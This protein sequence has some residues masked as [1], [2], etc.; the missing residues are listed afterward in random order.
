MK[1]I[2]IL[3]FSLLLSLALVPSIRS[4]SYYNNIGISI[5]INQW[6]TEE[7]EELLEGYFDL[8]IPAIQF[9]VHP[10]DRT[11]TEQF[12]TRVPNYES[13]AYLQS[14]TWV[15]YLAYF[16]TADYSV[17]SNP[18]T[19]VFY[20]HGEDLYFAS[21][22]KVVKINGV[23]EITGVSE[24]ITFPALKYYEK[25]DIILNYYFENETFEV[26]QLKSQKLLIVFFIILLG[27]SFS[28][29]HFLVRFLM[30]NGLR[31]D[32]EI[33]KKILFVQLFT[34]I[35]ASLVFVQILTLYPVYQ[36]NYLSYVFFVGILIFETVGLYLIF[37]DKIKFKDAAKNNLLSYIPY[38]FII[39]LL[40]IL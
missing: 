37:T 11:F 1:K 10:I 14:E 16:E 6:A 22:F 39:L 18:Y 40:M 21:A 23:G 30:L 7:D 29:M 36:P 17:R 2:L 9:P 27:I 3:C 5:T 38:A 26:T 20:S 8:L 15:S 32:N 34:A 28:F 4:M 25:Q 13:Y 31:V 35:P 24:V 19:V 12:M 33:E